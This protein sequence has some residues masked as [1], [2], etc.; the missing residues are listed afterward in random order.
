MRKIKKE[1]EEMFLLIY[2]K[3]ENSSYFTYAGI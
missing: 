1:Y 3:K 2:L